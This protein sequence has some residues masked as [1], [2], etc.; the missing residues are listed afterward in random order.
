MLHNL[1]AQ[2]E[3]A[4]TPLTWEAMYPAGFEETP[5]EVLRVRNQTTR[6]LIWADRLAPDLKRIH[7]VGTDLPQ[8][9]VALMAQAFSS[10]LFHTLYR[11]PSYQDWF[12]SDSQKIA[13]DI[14]ARMLQHLQSRRGN[15]VWVLKGPAHVFS[16]GPL[17][18]RYPDA[19][20]IQTHRDP[21]KAM[22][23]CEV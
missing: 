16:L 11:V 19:R 13:F 22:R 7:P 21:L 9:C 18:N 8:E 5:A 14:H 1:I 3:E 15:R 20:L 10:A 2:D 17:L 6:R 23:L 4:R 12:E